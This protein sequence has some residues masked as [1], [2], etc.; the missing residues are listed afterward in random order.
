MHYRKL[1][2]MPAWFLFKTSWYKVLKIHYKHYW[3]GCQ[4]KHQYDIYWQNLKFNQYNF[5]HLVLLWVKLL[6]QLNA[7]WKLD[8]TKFWHIVAISLICSLLL[9]VLANALTWVTICMFRITI[10]QWLI[11]SLWRWT[12]RYCGGQCY[13]LVAGRLF[14]FKSWLCICL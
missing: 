1:R 10:K 9:G 2:L 7:C 12:L 8:L 4:R 13:S 14:I 3:N 5:N 11:L 6:S